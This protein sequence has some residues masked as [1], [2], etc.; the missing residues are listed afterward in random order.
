[1]AS[2]LLPNTSAFTPTILTWG[3]IRSQWYKSTSYDGYG[4]I[5]SANDLNLSSHCRSLSLKLG[6]L[7]GYRVPG[8]I[9]KPGPYGPLVFSDNKKCR[10]GWRVKLTGLGVSLGNLHETA[11]GKV[12]PNS[13]LPALL[14]SLS[15][16]RWEIN[17]FSQAFLKQRTVNRRHLSV[18]LLLLSAC[19]SWGG[20][21][22]NYPPWGGRQRCSSLGVS[23][24]SFLR[25]V[26][27]SSAPA[28]FQRCHGTISGR[29]NLWWSHY[30]P[31]M[32][33]NTK[34]SLLE[35]HS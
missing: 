26:F 32:E 34:R 33:S 28:C 24:R 23:L 20:G 12:I 5:S 18:P 14:C 22:N 3:L 1:M 35:K 7:C 10:R 25:F 29:W 31:S 17:A 8:K 4:L 19:R 2:L 21:F 6:T 15:F 27:S 30:V 16:Q 11:Q 13:S 9:L